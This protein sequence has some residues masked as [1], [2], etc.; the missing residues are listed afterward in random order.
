MQFHFIQDFFCQFLILYDNI[1]RNIC[2]L[3]YSYTS[4]FL[5]TSP[6]FII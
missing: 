1:I 5:L 4:S 6:S 2:N 3:I